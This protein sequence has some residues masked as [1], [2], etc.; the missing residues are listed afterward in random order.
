MGEGLKRARKAARAT[1]AKPSKKE[2]YPRPCRVG[3]VGFAGMV[4]FHCPVHG[5][6]IACAC[7]PA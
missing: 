5:D 6:V 3:E 4:T 1:R 7:R 2:Q